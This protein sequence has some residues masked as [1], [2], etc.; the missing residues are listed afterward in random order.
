MCVIIYGPQGCGK[1]RNKEAL[2]KAVGCDEV[3]DD[4]EP[5][6]PVERNT[7]YLT[8]HPR[9]SA[10]GAKRVRVMPFDAAI[11]LISEV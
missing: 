10:P 6:D 4:W 9:P 8:W 1:T 7:L 2:R 5:G 11:K 3:V